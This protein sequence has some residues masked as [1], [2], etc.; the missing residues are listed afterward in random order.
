[1]LYLGHFTFHEPESETTIED[2]GFEGGS[3]TC[4]VEAESVEE[5][6]KKFSDLIISLGDSFEDLESVGNVYLESIIEVR[7][8]PDQGVLAHFEHRTAGGLGTIST[9]LPGVP[10]EFCVAYSWGREDDE[11]EDEYIMEP[12]VSFED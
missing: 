9:T 1:M 3:F 2:I 6:G 11:N 7:K 4:I 10:P 8:L 5:A 12:F